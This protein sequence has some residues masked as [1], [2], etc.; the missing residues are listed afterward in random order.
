MTYV[1]TAP[2]SNGDGTYHYEVRLMSANPSKPCD[3]VDTWVSDN[4]PM[5]Y[6]KIEI[7]TAV[8]PFSLDQGSIDFGK[9]SIMDESGDTSGTDTDYA[10]GT[11][12]VDS[13]TNSPLNPGYSSTGPTSSLSVDISAQDT[14]TGNGLIIKGNIQ[15]IICPNNNN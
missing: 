5:T 9:V 6:I 10:T 4:A 3:S 13:V 8:G 12:T 14:I 7:P 1:E 2:V 15:S 11:G